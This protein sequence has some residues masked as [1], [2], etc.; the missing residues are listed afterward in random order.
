MTFIVTAVDSQGKRW[1]R[2]AKQQWQSTRDERCHFPSAIEAGKIFREAIIAN[3][4][5]DPVDRMDDIEIVS[6]P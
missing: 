2:N 5:H 3:R 6:L 1:F 4:F